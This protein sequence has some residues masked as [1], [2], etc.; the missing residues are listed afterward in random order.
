MKR[1]VGSFAWT[2]A[3]VLRQISEVSSRDVDLSPHQLAEGLRTGAF[4]YLLDV[5]T[6]AEWESGHLPNATKMF[7]LANGGVEPTSILGCRDKNCT[8]AVYCTVGIRA[9]RAIARL[10]NEYGFRSSDLYNGGGVRQWSA[11][12]FGLVDSP[13]VVP[14]CEEPGYEC[15]SCST[16]EKD[17]QGVLVFETDSA[18]GPVAQAAGSFMI[19]LLLL[20]LPNLF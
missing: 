10:V 15:G 11:A 3:L 2:A 5:R 4:H 8:M 9:E 6:P 18:S 20:L 19:A 13:E 1:C 16:C 7:R 17:E 12:G 14:R